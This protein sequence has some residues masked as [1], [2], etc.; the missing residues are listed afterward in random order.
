MDHGKEFSTKYIG[1]DVHKDSITKPY[2]SISVSTEK[3]EAKSTHHYGLS[4]IKPCFH[5]KRDQALAAV[6]TETGNLSLYITIQVSHKSV[7]FPPSP[8]Q[9]HFGYYMYLTTE[10]TGDVTF[11]TDKKR[12]LYVSDS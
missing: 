4:P 2:V 10:K 12:F 9:I 7:W 11:V 1:L 8:C 6:D 5:L 3:F